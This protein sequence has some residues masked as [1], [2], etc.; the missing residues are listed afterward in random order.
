MLLLDENI[1][2]QKAQ[3]MVRWLT[4]IENRFNDP[5]LSVLPIALEG[6]LP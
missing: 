5:H 6:W 3:S 1:Q 4:T 2:Q